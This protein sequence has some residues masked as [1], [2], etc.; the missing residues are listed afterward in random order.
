MKHKSTNPNAIEHSRLC[1]DAS[2]THSLAP[3]DLGRTQ[4]ILVADDNEAIREIMLNTLANADFCVDARADGEEAWRAVQGGHYDLLV[5]D[6]DMPRLTGLELVKRI[7]DA[8]LRLPVIMASASISEAWVRDC[9]SLQVAVVPK[10]FALRD[11][12]NTVNNALRE[13]AAA[14]T[15]NAASFVQAPVLRSLPQAS[16]VK[17]DHPCVLIVDDDQTVRGSLAAA[18]ESEGYAVEEAGGGVEAVHWAANHPID[19][20]LL[21][22]NM[23]HGDGW[24]AF[25]ELDRVT[26]LLPVIVITARPNQYEE[27]VR[28]GVDAF[29]EKPLNIPVLVRAIK[30]FTSEGEDRHVSRIT[31]RSF[32]TQ[33]LCCTDSRRSDF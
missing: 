30:R 33:W 23:P 29:M 17:P 22:L 15:A 31:N 27:A 32:V 26:P 2:T 19:L 3:G 8:G 13:S 11:L 4:R 28:V 9:A 14:A 20:V 24:D 25:R 5:T 6:N 16:K 1:S 18:L 10:P 12:L 7:R 21:D